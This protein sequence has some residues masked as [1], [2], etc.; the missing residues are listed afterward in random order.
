MHKSWRFIPSLKA[1][2]VF[3]ALAML[4]LGSVA[5]AQDE[6]GDTPG[7]VKKYVLM[8]SAGWG[9]EQSAAITR[10]G[11]TVTFSH[12]GSG[13]GVASSA[14]PDFLRAALRSGAF[15]RGGLDMMVQW[16]D[17]NTR[18]AD[19]GIDL[20][21][22]VVTPGDETFVNEQWNIVGMNLPAAWAATGYTGAGVRIAVLDGGI[23]S[24]HVDLDGNL[25]VAKST[26][27]VPGFN[28]NQDT[29]TFWHG[30]HVAG[31]AAAEDNA[32]GTI[33]VAPGATIV[34]VKVLHNGSGSFEQVIAGILY[35]ADAIADG[36]GGADIINMSLGATF[37][38][39][40]GNTGA[41]PLVAAMNQAVNYA[42]GKGVL[43]VS[44][45]GNSAIDMDHA[46]SITNVPG[47]SGSGIAISATGPLGYA[48][49]WPNGNQDFD[50]PA[51]YTN[52]GNSLVWVAAPG[53][54]FAL[55]GNALC[56]IPRC[57]GGPAVN[58]NCWVHDMVMSTVRGSGASI[59]T[60]GWAA[61]TSMAA[62]AV[63][64]LA[65]LIKQRFPGITVGDLK[66]HIAQTADGVA[67]NDPLKPYYGHGFVN[68]YRALTEGSVSQAAASPTP[69]V[70]TA[71]VTARAELSVGSGRVPEISFSMPSAG[72]ARVDL[73]DVAGRRVAVLFSGY[74][75]AGR[76]VLS[77]DGHDSNGFKLGHGTYFARFMANDVTMSRKFV[78]IGE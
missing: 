12:A 76:T 14:D 41:G 61:G 58:T 24:T 52:Y 49:G 35:A 9:A 26:S 54:D 53:G 57:C 31:I 7:V 18:F 43:V 13:I 68:A 51:S 64:G 6:A 36:G 3:G 72:Q 30:T 1:L 19:E 45:A 39:G 42:T 55:P 48:V 56:A 69:K 10:L 4:A 17:P 75:G 77:W 34:G 78:K 27:F 28:F 21:E 8:K 65:A 33:G 60:Y 46:G 22:E 5:M 66:A 15:D 44:S 37:A 47:Q 63:S 71:A 38:K 29:G 2:A 40:G 11:G 23:H 67:G 73:F 20:E 62:P 74:A 16:Q 59:T 25:D 70:E 50:R 32:I